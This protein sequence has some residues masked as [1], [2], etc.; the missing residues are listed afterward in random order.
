MHGDSY[1]GHTAT[2]CLGQYKPLGPYAMEDELVILPAGAEQVPGGN[3]ATLLANVSYLASGIDRGEAALRAASG[4]G[5]CLTQRNSEIAGAISVLILMI[6]R[7]YIARYVLNINDGKNGIE[8]DLK[9]VCAFFET[10]LF[11]GHDVFTESCDSYLE[12]IEADWTNT[13]QAPV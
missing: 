9:A 11:R 7:T 1:V 13:G 8:G 12:R 2:R 6:C 3:G 10:G 4:I 5:F